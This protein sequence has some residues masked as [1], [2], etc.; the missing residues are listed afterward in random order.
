MGKHG[1]TEL[2][3]SSAK[4]RKI[5]ELLLEIRE[6]DVPEGEPPRKAIVFSQFTSFCGLKIILVRI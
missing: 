5:I 4:V 1:D 2:P 6:K 3:P